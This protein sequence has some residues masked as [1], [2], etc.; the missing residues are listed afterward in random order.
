MTEAKAKQKKKGAGPI[1]PEAV[2]AIGA[3]RLVSIS[4]LPSPTHCG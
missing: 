4:W 1:A 2:V 3:N